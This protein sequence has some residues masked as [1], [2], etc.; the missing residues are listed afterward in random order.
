MVVVLGPVWG[1]GFLTA[2]LTARQA[3][4]PGVWFLPE[5]ASPALL[6]SLQASHCLNSDPFCFKLLSRLCYLQSHPDF[7]EESLPGGT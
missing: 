7:A 4:G 3:G 1:G 6:L 2:L 5:P